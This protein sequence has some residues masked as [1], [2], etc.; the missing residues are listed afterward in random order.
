VHY[1]SLTARYKDGQEKEQG[2]RTTRQSTKST[3][4]GALVLKAFF[5]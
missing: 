5:N 1:S 4:E 2:D 3:K